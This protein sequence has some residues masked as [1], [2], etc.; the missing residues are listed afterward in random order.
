M[1]LS[2]SRKGPAYGLRATLSLGFGDWVT[3]LLKR[4]RPILEE[5]V[6]VILFHEQVIRGAVARFAPGSVP[7]ED[8]SFSNTTYTRSMG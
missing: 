2:I 7:K 6:G 4:L 1:G 5:T 8:F 3:S